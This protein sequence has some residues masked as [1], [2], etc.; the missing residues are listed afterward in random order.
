MAIFND[1]FPSAAS[2]T[3]PTSVPASALNVRTPEATTQTR[4]T[5]YARK[6]GGGLRTARKALICQQFGCLRRIEPGEFYFDTMEVTKWPATKRICA[7]C[8]EEPV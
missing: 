3:A 1:Q 4:A 6:N 7:C 5:F 2:V 8:A